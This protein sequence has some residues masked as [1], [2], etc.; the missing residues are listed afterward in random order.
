MVLILKIWKSNQCARGI[1]GVLIDYIL[2]FLYV[3]LFA[4]AKTNFSESGGV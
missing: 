4:R 1:I 3:F 2:L